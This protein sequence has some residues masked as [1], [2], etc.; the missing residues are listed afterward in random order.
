MSIYHIEC[1]NIN[2]LDPSGWEYKRFVNILNTFDFVQN[3]EI[4]TDSCGHLLDYLITRKNSTNASN[5]MVSDFIS[6]HR[7]LHVSLTCQRSH[8]C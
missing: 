3:I 5:F 7:V 2:Y 4:P 1:H 6:D 8:P